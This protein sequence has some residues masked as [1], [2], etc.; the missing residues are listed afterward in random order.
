MRPGFGS[1]RALHISLWLASL[2]GLELHV[3]KKIEALFC[4]CGS[5]PVPLR[6]EESPHPCNFQLAP[7]EREAEVLG[8]NPKRLKKWIR[9]SLSSRQPHKWRRTSR[10]ICLRSSEFVERLGAELQKSCQRIGLRSFSSLV[11]CEHK[12]FLFRKVEGCVMPDGTMVPLWDISHIRIQFAAC[13]F[14]RL[15]QTF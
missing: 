10:R 7:V 13:K 8:P 11:L 5:V 4:S 15:A 14:V 12:H 1:F 9:D 3:P 2:L 6:Y